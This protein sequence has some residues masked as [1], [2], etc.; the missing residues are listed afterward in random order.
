MSY[1]FKITEKSSKVLA[2]RM[3]IDLEHLRTK[4]ESTEISHY[5]S[6]VCDVINTLCEYVGAKTAEEVNSYCY[7]VIGEIEDEA[8]FVLDSIRMAF[9]RYISG[10][11]RDLFVYQENEHWFPKVILREILYPNDICS[12]ADEFLI[13]RGCDISEFE[14]R[15]FGQSW[16]IRES[17]AKDFAFKHYESQD[18]FDIKKRVVVRSKYKKCDTLY[19]DQTENGEFE[20]VVNTEM[21]TG[22]ENIT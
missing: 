10:G 3:C 22:I 21:L 18:W 5:T 19:S 11:L 2:D 16:T 20:I 7:S 4:I 9:Y 6:L 8:D 15:Q 1:M 13:Y 12:L 17:V 14:S